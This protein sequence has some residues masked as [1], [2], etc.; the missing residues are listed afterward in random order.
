MLVAVPLLFQFAGPVGVLHGLVMAS[1]VG[2]A[3]AWFT[4]FGVVWRAAGGVSIT[5]GAM[6]YGIVAGLAALVEQLFTAGLC[7]RRVP[8]RGR[9]LKPGLPRWLEASPWR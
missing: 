4:V 3:F 1:V 8:S 5:E 6:R 7:W 9:R 2:V